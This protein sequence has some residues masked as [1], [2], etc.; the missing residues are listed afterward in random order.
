MKN[1]SI[2]RVLQITY[3]GS[4]SRSTG[5]RDPHHLDEQPNFAKRRV[6]FADRSTA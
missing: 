4:R 3:G 6:R 2:E 1:P 5:F